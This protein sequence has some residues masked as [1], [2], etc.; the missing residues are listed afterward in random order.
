MTIQNVQYKKKH[1]FKCFFFLGYTNINSPF[2]NLEN[3]GT[4]P[5]N[6][7]KQI[8]L[9]KTQINIQYFRGVGE[10]MSGISSWY[11]LFLLTLL[12]IKSFWT[13]ILLILLEEYL[14]ITFDR[15]LL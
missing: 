11:N 13:N 6:V 2:D 1:F 15:S 8:P 7:L 5:L 4:L 3:V 14:F 10:I 12:E 9:K